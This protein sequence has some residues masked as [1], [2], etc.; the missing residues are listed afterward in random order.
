MILTENTLQ[1]T[2]RKNTFFSF[3]SGGMTSDRVENQSFSMT[4]DLMLERDS[5][6]IWWEEITS[7]IKSY[8]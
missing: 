1:N 2:N 7:D 3:T 6:V 8:F 5:V 4:Q